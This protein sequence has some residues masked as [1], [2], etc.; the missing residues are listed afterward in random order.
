[1]NKKLWVVM[2]FLISTTLMN[3]LLL[4]SV[5]LVAFDINVY[6]KAYDKYNLYET[7]QLSKSDYVDIS[8][9][10]LEYLLG[11]EDTLCN[12]AA[13]HDNNKNLFN[14]KELSHMEDVKSLFRAGYIIRSLSFISLI[15]LIILMLVINKGQ[16]K[17]AGKAIFYS[18]I[19]S[20]LLTIFFI[21]LI[22][23]DFYNYFTVFHEILFTN[24][25]WLLNPKT[26]LLINMF[27]LDFFNAMAV[28]IF[29][30]FTVQLLVVGALGYYVYRKNNS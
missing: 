15:L 2:I 21:A 25:L 20:L 22:N 28:R 16:K 7:T 19:I 27:P 18:S 8:H 10:I 26:D 3:S 29:L 5:Q 1:M 4:T 9:K 14:P 6:N 12:S 11:K 23:T 30:Y 24:D 13:I 17:Y